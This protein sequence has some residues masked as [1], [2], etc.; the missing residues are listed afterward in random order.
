MWRLARD[1]SGTL[2]ERVSVQTK[3]ASLGWV[4]GQDTL[5]SHFA[6]L[7]PGK[8]NWYRRFF[9]LGEGGGKKEGNCVMDKHPIQGGVAIPFI[10]LRFWKKNTL[11]RMGRLTRKLSL[12]LRQKNR[13]KKRQNSWTWVRWWAWSFWPTGFSLWS[14]FFHRCCSGR[15][16][17]GK[18]KTNKLKKNFFNYT[19][20]ISSP[21]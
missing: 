5:L 17:C 21:L 14:A 18:L 13:M 12:P 2:E 19:A 20:L 9:F 6:F 1:V 7:Y 11:G 3:A 4:G 10:T 15:R 8:I 16:W